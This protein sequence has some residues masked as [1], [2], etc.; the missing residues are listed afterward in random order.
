MALLCG[1]G[2]ARVDAGLPGSW[3]GV[4]RVEAV[5]GAA[6][7]G[8]GRAWRRC[9]HQR[10]HVGVAPRANVPNSVTTLYLGGLFY[11]LHLL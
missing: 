1:A 4:G 11:H 5:V 8:S 7:R 2:A 10:R 3:V 6:V 9:A